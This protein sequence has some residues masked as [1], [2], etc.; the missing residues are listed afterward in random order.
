MS[1]ADDAAPR[2]PPSSPTRRS[3]DLTGRAATFR[4]RSARGRQATPWS[5]RCARNARASVL[6]GYPSRRPCRSTVASRRRSPLD[7]KS[8]RLN[9]SHVR[10]SYAVFCLKKKKTHTHAD[11]SDQRLHVSTPLVLRLAVS[12]DDA[13]PVFDDLVGRVEQHRQ[14]PQSLG[15]RVGRRL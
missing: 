15:D 14:P 1:C 11:A 8:T 7:R 12:L 4:S 13:S 2:D 6:R 9:S 3:S 5:C 10:I